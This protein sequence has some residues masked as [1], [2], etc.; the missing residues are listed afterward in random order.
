MASHQHYSVS[1]YLDNVHRVDS[2][3]GSVVATLKDTLL[4][5][6]LKSRAGA[7]AYTRSQRSLLYLPLVSCLS[8]SKAS[9]KQHLDGHRALKTADA[10]QSNTS[11]SSCG[12]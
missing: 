4:R 6:I 5:M 1:N 11:W 2:P 3:Q 8:T 12:I 7:P 10:M 9:F